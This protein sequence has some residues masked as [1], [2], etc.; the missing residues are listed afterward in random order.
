MN[1][2]AQLPLPAFF[3]ALGA[4]GLLS[5][6]DA[7]VK[8]LVL[9]L[10]I[11]ST[12]LWRSLAS[13]LL[14]SLLYLPRRRAW[15]TRTVLRIHLLRGL[16]MAVMAFLFFWGLGRVPMA[17]AISLTFIAP[18]IALVL[19]A[20]TLGETIGPRT[21][22]GALL[23]LAGVG[24][25]MLGELRADL[26]REALLGSGAIILS[27]L[28]Y[29]VNIVLMRTQAMA[30]RPLE[31]SFFQNLVVA[32]CMVAAL[33]LAGGVVPPHG[34]WPAIAI[35]SV[36]SIAGALLFAWAYA[37]AEAGYLAVTEYS[38]FVWASLFGWLVF[39]ERVAAATLAGAVL[40]VAG[41]WV[42][43]RREKR[44]PELAA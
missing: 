3:A 1:R 17:Q 41:C 28:C 37:R 11:F 33:P 12:M 39:G 20:A 38:G 43:A 24:V 34:Q 10:G 7:A 26:G 40:I 35:A 21:V 2:V 4:V 14:S 9:A 5:A 13:L 15:P 23:A 30:A 16:T 6:M 27:A 25:I 32:G 36:L 22:A 44:V 31:I 42:A 18:L 8:T 29:A 19:A